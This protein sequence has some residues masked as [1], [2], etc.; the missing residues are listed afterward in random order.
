MKHKV[1][2][3]IADAVGFLALCQRMNETFIPTGSRVYAEMRVVA[4]T[5]WD[6]IVHP[7]L[8]CGGEPLREFLIIY[9]KGVTPVGVVE[10]L[11][12]GD[13]CFEKDEPKPALPVK[14]D[15]NLDCVTYVQSPDK[16][17]KINLIFTF[18]LAEFV[19][20]CAA[21]DTLKCQHDE[22][23]KVTWDKEYRVKRFKQLRDAHM[24]SCPTPTPMPF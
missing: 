9:N 13:S 24:R 23:A 3:T 21:T 2:Y 22:A 7:Y 6:F 20:W 17:L 15:D 5:D 4:D 1:T 16:A 18:S 19:G 11:F 14:N 12:T 10:P 8:H